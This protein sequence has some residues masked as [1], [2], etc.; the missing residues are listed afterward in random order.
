MIFD[1][2][3][4]AFASTFASM[5]AKCRLFE[6]KKGAGKAREYFNGTSLLVTPMKNCTSQSIYYSTR[7]P[8]MIL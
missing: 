1:D 4:L 6:L 5:G 2:L 8:H 7:M 3:K